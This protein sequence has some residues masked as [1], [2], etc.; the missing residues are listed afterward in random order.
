LDFIRCLMSQNKKKLQITK[1]PKKTKIQTTEEQT[2][3]N[4]HTQNTTPEYTN[5]NKQFCVLC[6]CV[7]VCSGL[8]FCG[9]Y[10]GLLGV[11]SSLS[12]IFLV[13]GHQTM[14]EIQKYTSI[15]VEH[16][17][18][19]IHWLLLYFGIGDAQPITQWHSLCGLLEFSLSFSCTG[20]GFHI[21]TKILHP[22]TKKLAN[23]NINNH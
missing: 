11:F 9:L 2:W 21:C 14:D 8:L 12:I 1:N 17:F 4:K 18:F 22:C 23:G 19:T 20:S 7:F 13:L 10:F 15:N 16:Y 3:T 5:G 6:V